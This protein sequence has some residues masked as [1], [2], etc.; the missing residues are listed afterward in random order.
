[1]SAKFGNS[2]ENHGNKLCLKISRKNQG[3]GQGAFHALRPEDI[4]RGV[5]MPV[6]MGIP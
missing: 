2:G 6:S 5:C 4:W 3:I 1:M